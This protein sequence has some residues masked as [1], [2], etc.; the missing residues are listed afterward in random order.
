MENSEKIKAKHVIAGVIC[1]I[2]IFFIMVLIWNFFILK[3]V[4]VFVGGIIFLI[5]G[6]IIAFFIEVI[7]DSMY[8]RKKR[9]KLSQQEVKAQLQ[10]PVIS[11]FCPICGKE[12]LTLDSK[13]CSHCGSRLEED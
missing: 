8:Y 12:L 13:F 6:G 7:E 9:E 10:E 4:Y 5:V 2:I 11:R 3:N 1:I